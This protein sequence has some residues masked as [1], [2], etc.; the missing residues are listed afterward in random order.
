MIRHEIRKFARVLSCQTADKNNIL[1]KSYS[2]HKIA[3]G[4]SEQTIPLKNKYPNSHL[5]TLSKPFHKKTRHKIAPGYSEQTLPQKNTTQTCA[6][7]LRA[8]CF[9]KRPYR[10]LHLVI[11][12]KDFHKHTLHKLAPD[13]FEQTVPQRPYTKIASGYSEQPFHKQTPTQTGTWLR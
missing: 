3:P 4:Y 6:W 13:Y 9:T 7:L 12:R 1:K 8:N 5:V 11:L 10:K 2:L